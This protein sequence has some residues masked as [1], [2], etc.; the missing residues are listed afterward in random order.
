MIISRILPALISSEKKKSVTLKLFVA[1]ILYMIY[2]CLHFTE[3]EQKA[4]IFLSVSITSIFYEILKEKAITGVY[5]AR[6][7]REKYWKIFEFKDLFDYRS[8]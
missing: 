2:A 3:V 6:Y 7:A 8:M 5:N 4:H 1:F